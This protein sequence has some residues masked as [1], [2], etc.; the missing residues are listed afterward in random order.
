M[1][2]KIEVTSRGEEKRVMYF[3]TIKELDIFKDEKLE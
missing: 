2:K 3:D 1:R